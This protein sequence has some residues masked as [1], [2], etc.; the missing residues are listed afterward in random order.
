MNNALIHGVF[1]PTPLS[2]AVSQRKCSGSVIEFF[3][4]MFR[5]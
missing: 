1:C 3:V 5:F 2:C 4:Q